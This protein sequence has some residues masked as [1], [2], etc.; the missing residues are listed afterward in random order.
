MLNKI[1]NKGNHLSI[2]T[3]HFGNMTIANIREQGDSVEIEFTHAFIVKNMDAA[4]EDTRW[5]SGGLI[6]IE[7]V[8]QKFY[9]FP[10]LPAQLSGADLRDN[11]MIYRDEIAIPFSIH[12]H[13][14]I[15]MR[16]AESDT[17]LK[18]IGEKMS[19]TLDGHE[20]YIE[21]IKD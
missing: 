19:L 17:A 11:Q 14:G 12:G 10:E 20:K 8:E 18:L 7:G 4:E 16:F 15:E 2:R 13:V 5:Y 3:I 1:R 6:K 21:H 9:D